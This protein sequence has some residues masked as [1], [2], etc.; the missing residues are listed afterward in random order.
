MVSPGKGNNKRAKKSI[1]DDY[2]LAGIKP[3]TL[4]LQSNQVTLEVVVY[5][6]NEP[7]SGPKPDK[8]MMTFD[9]MSKSSWV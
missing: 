6:M 8:F 1:F 5:M 2:D 7:L 9:L 4:K 3:M